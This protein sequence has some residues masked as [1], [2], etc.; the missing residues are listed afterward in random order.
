MGGYANASKL[1]VQISY[2][3]AVV[4]RDLINPYLLRRMKDDVDIGLPSKQERVLFCPLQVEQVTAYQD[5]LKSEEVQWVMSLEKSGNNMLKAVMMLRKICNHPDLVVP[6]REQFANPDFGNWRR[7]GKMRVIQQLLPLWK[8][9]GHRVLWFT[10]T[11]RMLRIMERFAEDCGYTFLSMDGTTSIG[12]RAEK[13]DRFNDDPSHFLFLLT[14][15]TGGLGINLTGADRVI[16]FDPD[17]NPS[18]DSQAR[19][20][21]W[22]IGQ[23][24]EVAVYRLITSG[25]VEEKIYQRQIYKQF[26]TNKILKDP[27]QKRFFHSRVMKDLLTL[28]LTG[29][30]RSETGDIFAE[31]NGELVQNDFPVARKRAAP[32]SDSEG[33]PSSPSGPASK[34]R[35]RSDDTSD[36]ED[37]EEGSSALPN[38]TSEREELGSGEA[39][40]LVAARALENSAVDEMEEDDEEMGGGNEDNILAQ[41]F[42]SNGIKSVLEHDAIMDQPNPDHMFVENEG[43]CLACHLLS[44]TSPLP[45]PPLCQSSIPHLIRIY[46]DPKAASM[47]AQRAARLLKSSKTRCDKEQ[48]F[49]PTWTGRAGTAG[50][51]PPPGR[52][53][54]RNRQERFGQVANSRLQQFSVGR[55]SVRDAGKAAMVRNFQTRPGIEK[56]GQAK[57]PVTWSSPSVSSRADASRR[58]FQVIPSDV[59]AHAAAMAAPT[60][61][62]PSA[63]PKNSSQSSITQF[64]QP[65]SSAGAV[66]PMSSSSILQGIRERAATRT[67]Q[68]APEPSPATA[69]APLSKEDAENLEHIKLLHSVRAPLPHTPWYLS[70]PHT[71]SLISPFSSRVFSPSTLFY[72]RFPLTAAQYLL[73]EGGEA[74]SNDIIHK[75]G[76]QL[77]SR[78]AKFVFRSML[79]EIAA[80]DRASQR[81]RLRPTYR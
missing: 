52:H 25:T 17:W 79:K 80:F 39:A 31:I 18:T 30:G 1:Q 27:R 41:L 66:Q 38:P 63:G 32:D 78:E 15:R 40:A 58:L 43:G 73:M 49:V 77:I 37:R 24:K 70:R 59:R 26:L 33:G 50:G 2:K 7:S 21:A 55:G 8:K 28:Q 22:R 65:S 36:C 62:P 3:C 16:I 20:R 42:S 71:R 48:V 67:G 57:A 35:R 75:F 68:P 53:S 64:F 45:L 12:S 9:E 56:V 54:K 10:Q 69:S 11:R 6:E 14:T 5:Y 47:V 23:K 4:L 46:I 60:E 74:S 72:L 44:H 76:V 81:W 61:P 29:E 34:K 51:P 13:I 19:E